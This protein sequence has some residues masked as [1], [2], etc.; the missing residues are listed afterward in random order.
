MRTKESRRETL[1]GYAKNLRKKYPD[2]EHWVTRE[3]AKI[4]AA[5]RSTFRY[6]E[7]RKQLL[8]P[9]A[10]YISAE[11]IHREALEYN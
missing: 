7:T 5:F 1:K 8:G 3:L 10:E 2:L 11:E 9:M 4:Q 6:A